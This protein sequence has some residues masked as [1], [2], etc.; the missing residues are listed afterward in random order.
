[1]ENEEYSE[2]MVSLRD[3]IANGRDVEAMLLSPGGKRLM[4]VI[5]EVVEALKRDLL[6][7][8][9][10]EELVERWEDAKR[11][12][13]IGERLNNEVLISREAQKELNELNRTVGMKPGGIV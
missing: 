11:W 10:R 6:D 8:K 5:N 1:M 9:T 7:V 2:E 3:V 4:V 12:V 13:S